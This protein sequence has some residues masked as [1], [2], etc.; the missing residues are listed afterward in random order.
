MRPRAM[1]LR[2]APLAPRQCAA[3]FPSCSG[4]GPPAR[5]SIVNDA[6]RLTP[7][8]SGGV[9]LGGAGALRQ[10]GA[11]SYLQLAFDGVIEGFSN[12]CANE[13][14]DPSD[15][16]PVFVV[17]VVAFRGSHLDHGD[18]RIVLAASEPRPKRRIPDLLNPGAVPRNRRD[19]AQV[20][21]IRV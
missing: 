20:Q 5:S 8:R 18:P 10:R 16:V 3:S 7:N 21:E 4:T 11:A 12:G 6:I 17:P 15:R 13:H 19:A 1:Q 14:F 2:L 9:S